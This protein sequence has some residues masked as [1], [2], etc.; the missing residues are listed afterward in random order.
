VNSSAVVQ[1]ILTSGPVE[2]PLPLR[3]VSDWHLGHPGSQIQSISQVSHLLDGVGTFLVVGDGREELVQGWRPQADRLWEE[4]QENCRQRGV[5]FLALTGNHDP[6][7]SSEGWLEIPSEQMLITHG[8]MI[9]PETSPWSRE[10]FNNREEVQRILEK[11][12]AKDLLTRWQQAREI[13]V[14]LRPD[15]SMNPDFLD[16][17]KLAFWPPRRLLE[18]LKVWGH[19]PRAGALFLSDFASQCD[20][21]ICGHFHRG[22]CFH[23]AEKTIW[24]LGS[25]MKACSGY[26]I[27]FAPSQKS[28]RWLQE[29]IRLE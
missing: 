21:L 25:L 10:L 29:R 22:G 26:S 27:T 14:C 1:G 5:K 18:A 4:L 12:D 13:G 11:W 8:D 15:S 19:F 23:R 6:S 9:Y 3:C 28:K 20:S 17:L 7:C 2:L 24:N 16:Y